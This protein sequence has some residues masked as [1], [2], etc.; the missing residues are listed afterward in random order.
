MRTSDKA[1]TWSSP[2]Q[3]STPAQGYAF[4][5]GVSIAPSGRIDVG[6]QALKAKDPSTFGTGNAAIDSW[7]ASSTDHGATFTAPLRISHD[8]QRPGCQRSEQPATT[9]L[10][11]LQP[12]GLLHRIAP[13][14][15]TPT[16][17]TVSGVPLSMPTSSSWSPMAW[18]CAATWQ[19]GS[20]HGRGQPRPSSLARSRPPTDCTPPVRQ[21]R[22][23]R[24][25]HHPLISNHAATR[26]QSGDEAAC[27]YRPGAT[28]GCPFG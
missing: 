26:S 6:Y 20:L 7:Y 13:G 25:H 16:P 21:L 14:S 12:D 10:R 28:D 11:R 4:Y 18:S 19:T 9:V 5:Q 27:R 3:V 1:R 17:G 23:L 24:Q 15:S 22:C 2:V 8:L